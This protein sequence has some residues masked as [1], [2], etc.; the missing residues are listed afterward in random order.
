[1]RN[2][3]S[4]SFS[5]EPVPRPTSPGDASSLA[6][7]RDGRERSHYVDRLRST[8]SRSKPGPNG[9]TLHHSTLPTHHRNPR[10]H[11]ESL[12]DELF[13]ARADNLECEVTLGRSEIRTSGDQP[14][15][16]R[17]AQLRV[18]ITLS[19]DPTTG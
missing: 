9:A 16:G 7:R 6:Y 15:G 4:T 3:Y 11:P 14:I 5:A 13:D 12:L 19:F 1:M 18:S 17:N 10:S 8:V 2:K